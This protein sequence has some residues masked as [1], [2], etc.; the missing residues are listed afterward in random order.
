VPLESTLNA[1]WASLGFLAIAGAIAAACIRQN[2]ARSKRLQV[3]C[4]ALVVSALFPYI[5]STD[6]ALRLQYLS[7]QQSS[8]SEN[9]GH[10]NLMRLYEATDAPIAGQIYSLAI[11]LFT[12]YL[13]SYA[14]VSGLD[15]SIPQR[16]GRS[17]PS[18]A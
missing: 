1:L 5:S 6:D 2:A 18:P 13:V 8:S 3:V 4:I 12:L 7:A 16:A 15:R 11:A 10:D 14:V 9:H 17:P